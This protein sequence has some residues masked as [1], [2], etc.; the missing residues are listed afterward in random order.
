MTRRTKKIK[1]GKFI[2]EGAYGCVF[3]NPPLKCEGEPKRRSNKYISKLSSNET[4]NSEVKRIDILKSIDSTGEYF[5]LPIDS[6][7]LNKSS[8]EPTNMVDKCS[9]KSYNTLVFSKHGG[10]DLTNLRLPYDEYIPFFNSF[11]SLFE[12]IEKL[13][14]MKYVHC[15]IKLSNILTQKQPDNTFKTRL[16]D[17]DLLIEDE[18]LFLN[19]DQHYLFNKEVYPVWPLEVHFATTDN[20]PYNNAILTKHINSW[21]DK[22]NNYGGYRSLP[23]KS[24]WKYNNEPLFNINSPEIQELKVLEYSKY[25]LSSLDIFSLGIALSQI[26]NM[27]L[28]YYVIVDKT[29]NDSVRINSNFIKA[30]DNTNKTELS[31]WHNNIIIIIYTPIYNLIRS[32]IHI[33]PMKRL[34]ITQV[35]H[36]Y[37]IILNE[38]NKLLTPETLKKYLPLNNTDSSEIIPLSPP[39]VLSN[40]LSG[41]NQTRSRSRSRNRNKNNKNFL[42]STTKNYKTK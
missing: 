38:I 16:I 32:M 4:A 30:S 36:D 41:I 10:K 5:I 37:K 13:H 33:N 21:Y 23:G 31:E 39:P 8:I 15:D 42:G 7:K 17:Y 20:L 19:E 12:G 11:V 25:R 14:N 26:F 2:S 9:R 1:G 22:Q 27:L 28:G 6:C 24:Y 3:G 35:I 18:G 29:N 40:K 34:N